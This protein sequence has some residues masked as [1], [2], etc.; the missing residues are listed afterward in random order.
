MLQVEV[1]KLPSFMLGEK[2]GIEKGIE[3]GEKRKAYCVAKRL[4]SMKMSIEQVAQITELNKTE[5]E[6]LLS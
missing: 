4:L 1:E 3:T 6:K 5:I 2:K